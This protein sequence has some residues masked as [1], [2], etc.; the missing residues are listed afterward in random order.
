MILFVCHSGSFTRPDYDNAMHT[1]I[2]R[3]IR[4]GYSSVIAPMWSLNTEILSTWLS[5][6]MREVTS[7][8]FVIDALFQA[9]IAVKEEYICPEVYACLHL[10]GNPFLQIAKK[11]I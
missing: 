5:T 3:Y 11:T 1:L 2:K 10:F 8:Q 4:V 7:G 9:N 6:F